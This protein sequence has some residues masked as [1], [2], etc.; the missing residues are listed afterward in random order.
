MHRLLVILLVF[1]TS[2]AEAQQAYLFIKKGSRKVRSFPE[3]SYVRL[4]TAEGT[5]QGYMTYLRHDTVYLNNHP[6]PVRSIRKVYDAEAGTGIG[7]ETVLYTT[8]GIVLT[9]VALRVVENNGATR[10]QV[11][12]PAVLG[13]GGLL[14]KGV[15]HKL[16]HGRSV[17]PI[18]RK[19][20]LQVF[21]LRPF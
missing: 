1:T 21:E 12:G 5:R 13:F 14:L 10:S 17:Y 15:M 4:Q 6:L 19:F 2:F 8:M 3:G 11:G 16:K 20:R 18:G 9:T 7:V